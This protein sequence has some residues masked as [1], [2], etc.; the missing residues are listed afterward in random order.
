MGSISHL[1]STGWAFAH[2]QRARLLIYVACSAAALAASLA[3]PFIIGKVLDA[4]QDA[5]ASDRGARAVYPWLGAFLATHLSFWALHGPA[6]VLEREVA[7]A[8]RT[9][10][11]LGL[12]RIVL[13]LPLQWHRDHHSGETIA[14]IQRAGIALGA[15]WEGSFELIHILARFL[16][17][18]AVLTAFLPGAG[19]VAGTITLLAVLGIRAFDRKLVA[20]GVRLNALLD[21]VASAVHD[22]VTN[23]TTVIT[24][25]VQASVSEEVRARRDAALPVA[26]QGFVI[27]ELKWFGATAVSTLA[28]AGL[29]GWYATV[30]LPAHGALK[31]GA[32]FTFFE[33]LRRMGDSC[34]GLAFKY[35]AVVK[36]GLD[37]QGADAIRAAHVNAVTA[38]PAAEKPFGQL[39]IEQL[40]LSYHDEPQ[41]P[42]AL[43]DI[44]LALE[45]GKAI[46][47]VGA[48]GSG[49]S[50]LLRALRGLHEPA[51]ARVLRDGTVDADGLAAVSARATLI[52]QD[53]E[54]FADTIRFNVGFGVAASDYEIV[55]ALR[56][57]RFEPVL[58]RLPQGL[59]THVAEKG[60]NLSGGEKQ[61][62]ALARGVFFARHSP[63]VLLD[64]PTS[65][66]DP[67]N[68]RLIYLE[69]LSRFRDRALVCSL[70][71]LHLL[72]LFDHIV[73]LD[74]GCIVE[75][76]PFNELVAR[77]GGTLAQLWRSYN[78]PQLEPASAH[79]P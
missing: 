72:P 40:E 74:G 35:G 60:V 25:R 66:V 23:A 19:L 77:E 79:G 47:L 21:R 71:R 43:R 3:E 36:Q 8:I 56:A 11:E 33:Y 38:V 10:F 50:T 51:R 24:L 54:L 13:A 5:L 42:L 15:F 70:H 9:Q 76:G 4:V 64:E 39:R 16:G 7:F 20:L 73:V 67:H 27:N 57:A 44:E 41:R 14:R 2:G 22:Y 37:L 29:F 58:A 52:P 65:S 26:R 12:F 63:I 49:K 53:P 69:L 75:Q 30:E 28:I 45:P 55:E 34:Y 78:G 62:L 68:E 17:S 6:R 61:R 18:L 48:S 59:D 1:V 46:A 31:I 32:F